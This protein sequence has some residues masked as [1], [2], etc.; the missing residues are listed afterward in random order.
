LAIVVEDN[1]AGLERN[2]ANKRSGLGT[3]LVERFVSEMGAAHKVTSSPAGTRHTI[4]VPS[5]D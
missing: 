1:G 3:R 4:L 5:L 2:R